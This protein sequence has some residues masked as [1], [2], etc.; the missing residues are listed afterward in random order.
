MSDHLTETTKT[1]IPKMSDPLAETPRRQFVSASSFSRNASSFSRNKRRFTVSLPVLLAETTVTVS[2]E[3]RY[4]QNRNSAWQ[5]NARVIG[6]RQSKKSWVIQK[7]P[8]SS[9]ND[10]AS[11]A[12]VAK[13]AGYPFGNS[14]SR[15]SDLGSSDFG[16]NGTRN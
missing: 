8:G 13:A 10:I 5:Q 1:P 11:L 9:K 12:N 4:C 3:F 15:R 7:R 16:S 6:H 2:F 14:D